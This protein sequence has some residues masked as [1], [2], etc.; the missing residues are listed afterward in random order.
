VE[1]GSL[2]ALSEPTPHSVSQVSPPDTAP[3][4]KEK[5]RSSLAWVVLVGYLALLA[6]NVG[7]PLVLLS[8]S[9][10]NASGAKDLILAI[11][12]ALSGLVGVLGF[13]VG[14][15]FKLDLQDRS[16]SADPTA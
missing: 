15:Y 8:I 3:V 14:Y 4:A 7:G 13:V 5:T 1:V 2:E 12:G 11:S 9:D 6:V 16:P 10:I